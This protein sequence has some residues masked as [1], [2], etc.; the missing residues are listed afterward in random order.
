M[1]K[2]VEKDAVVASN[3]DPVE[4]SPSRHDFG[5]VVI[6]NSREFGPTVQQEISQSGSTD[7]T[8]SAAEVEAANKG[9]LARGEKVVVPSNVATQHV[10]LEKVDPQMAE[11]DGL[12]EDTQ[13][14]RQSANVRLVDGTKRVFHDPDTGKIN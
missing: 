14:V 7:E 10:P 1:A 3:P 5:E 8:V 2:R 9:R 4:N 11:V 6:A 13:A 12:G